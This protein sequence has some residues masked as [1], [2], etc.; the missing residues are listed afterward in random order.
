MSAPSLPPSSSSFSSAHGEE[1]RR[2]DPRGVVASYLVLLLRTL[3]VAA[4]AFL[5]AKDLTLALWLVGLPSLGVFVLMFGFGWLVWYR[6]T[7]TTGADAICVEQGV[8]SRRARAVPYERMQDV[9]IEQNLIPRLFGLTAVKFETGAGGKDEITLAYVT[10][11]EAH[12]LRSLVRERKQDPSARAAQGGGASDEI[13]GE[14]QLLFAMD[15]RRVLTFGLFEFSL[16]TVGLLLA[17][18]TNFEFLLPFDIFDIDAWSAFAGAHDRELKVLKEHRRIIGVLAAVVT[19]VFLV[20]VGFVSGLGNTMIRDHGFRLER[21]AKGFRRR[22]G[23]LTRSDV[24]MPAH[25]VQAA[26]VTT[27]ILRRR[28]GW[29]GL[30]FISLATDAKSSSH[31]VAPFAQ[32][33]EIAPVLALADLALPDGYTPWQPPSPAYAVDRAL[34]RA[35]ACCVAAVVSMVM[36]YAAAGVG[37][38][39]LAVLLVARERFRWQFERHALQAEYVFVRRGWLSPRTDIGV[40][41]KVQS[42][43]LVQNPLAQWR[44]YATIDLGIA[45]GSLTIPGVPLLRA[46]ALVH[47]IVDRAAAIDFAA[48]PR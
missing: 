40:R 18:P 15:D 17:I 30:E 13:P 3:P 22:R 34:L 10:E 11:A 45:G 36:G 25:R 24:V 1:P 38:V 19:A 41:T 6:R 33:H 5:N 35:G 44:G 26:R 7:Y 4:L 31:C 8:L 32:L 9:S 23:L 21:T 47:D 37:L 28:F 42:V 27:G 29:H 14:G 48:L 2:T 39:A 20:V 46:R 12:R 16:V 43:E